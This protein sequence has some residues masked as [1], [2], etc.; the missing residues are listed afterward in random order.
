MASRHVTITYELCPGLEVDVSSTYVVEVPEQGPTYSSGGQPCEPAHVEDITVLLD[1]IE[2][3][4]GGLF[5]G[6]GNG[7]GGIHHYSMEQDI[8]EKIVDHVALHG[9]EA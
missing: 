1:G 8:E 4:V 9:A 3:D 7:V 2:L 5:L 6:K